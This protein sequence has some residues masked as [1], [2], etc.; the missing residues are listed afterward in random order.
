[1]NKVIIFFGFLIGFSPLVIANGYSVKIKKPKK[2]EINV[3]ISHDDQVKMFKCLNM[4]KKFATA[5][6]AINAKEQKIKTMCPEQGEHSMHKKC[7]YKMEKAKKYIWQ[8]FT[9]RDFYKDYI[10]TQEK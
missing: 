2:V 9:I 1:M 10:K 4:L 6:E 3:G 8:C 5:E 7:Q